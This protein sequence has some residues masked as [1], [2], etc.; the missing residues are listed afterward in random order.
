M[1]DQQIGAISKVNDG[2]YNS[3][4]FNRAAQYR[5]VQRTL[6]DDQWNESDIKSALN[7]LANELNVKMG[8]LMFP[9]RVLV[10]GQPGGPDLMPL[11]DILGQKSSLTRSASVLDQV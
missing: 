5:P 1:T 10:T 8:K 11:L 9:L 6:S 4:R 7:D 3:R 2:S